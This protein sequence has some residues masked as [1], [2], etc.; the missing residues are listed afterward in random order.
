MRLYRFLFLFLLS[1]STAQA[2]TQ[3]LLQLIDYV[4]VD[5]SGAVKNGEVVN[6]GEYAEM[7]DFSAG[8]QQQFQQLPEGEVKASLL[9]DVEKLRQM[10]TDKANAKEVNQLSAQM[11]MQILNG[12]QIISTP[13]KQPDLKHA[14]NIYM[15]QCASC[16]GDNGFGDGVMAKGLE[17]APTNFHDTERY[18]QRTS[19]SLFSTITQ[20]V[21]GTAMRAFPEL[22]DHERWSLAFYVGRMGVDAESLKAGEA[23]RSNAEITSPL[24]ELKTFTVTTPGEAAM[25]GGEQGAALMSY[26]RQY[27]EALFSKKSPLDFSIKKLDESLQAYKDNNKKRA[28]EYAVEAYLEGYELV[29]K[30]LDA[31]DPELRLQVENA[32][33]GLRQ[34][35][36]SDK[37]VAE[38]ATEIERIQDLLH[39]VRETLASR[40][41]SGGSAFAAS[42]FIILREGLEALLVVVALAAFLVKTNR[43]DG[44]IYIHM[45]WMGALVAGFATWLLS[46]TLI[47]ISGVSREVTEG[48]AAIISTLVLFYVGYWMQNKSHLDK[49]KNFIDKSINKVLNE[50]GLWGLAGLSFIAVYREVFESILFYQ[51][52]WVQTDTVGKSMVMS[53]F[54]SAVGVLAVLAWLI[55]RYSIKLP[56][57][58]FFS[59]AGILMLSLAV[60]FAG[61]GVAALQEAGFIPITS[62]SFPRIDLL[63]VYPNMQGLLLQAGLVIL[64]LILL[65]RK[66]EPAK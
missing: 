50:G 31:L 34:E 14:A 37:P 35:M 27:P 1:F 47:D 66:H 46:I 44:L 25:Q 33:T 7:Q 64:A 63:G 15:Q 28:Y 55:M 11:R 24:A 23:L 30:G 18:S 19:Y 62:V 36:R 4:G 42:A 5:Y 52:L 26:F 6:P 16:H 10:I 65:T 39:Q 9:Q 48:V 12:Y 3:Q 2:S 43:R 51:A 58:Q 53:G 57:R 61:K 56:L 60:I 41:M 8:I 45:G 17:P 20:G 21:S 22:S 13:R 38:I 40:T 54:L 59:V 32:M 49:W 29:E